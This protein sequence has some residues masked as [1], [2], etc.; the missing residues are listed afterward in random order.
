MVVK[1]LYNPIKKWTKSREI[2]IVCI[3]FHNGLCKY[4]FSI[5]GLSVDFAVRIKFLSFE[6]CFSHVILKQIF[7]TALSI[8]LWCFYNVKIFSD[9][10]KIIRGFLRDLNSEILF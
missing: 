1:Y 2:D 8:G 5:L 4:F 10:I 3:G 9:V 7:N 6:T